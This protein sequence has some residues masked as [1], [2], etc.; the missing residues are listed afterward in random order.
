MDLDPLMMSISSLY[1]ASF[2]F[3]YKV[4]FTSNLPAFGSAGHAPPERGA[5]WTLG[6]TDLSSFGGSAETREGILLLQTIRR[7]HARKTNR[8]KYGGLGT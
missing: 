1:H 2:V 8:R 3:M 5:E 6:D 4:P 7:H